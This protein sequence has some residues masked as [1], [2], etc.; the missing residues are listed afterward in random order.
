LAGSNRK[1]VFE[2]DAV[3]ISV[4]TAGYKTGHRRCE[5]Y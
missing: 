2:V 1:P 4:E 3:R 5:F